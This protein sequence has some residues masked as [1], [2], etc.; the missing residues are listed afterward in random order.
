MGPLPGPPRS[1]HAAGRDLRDR[2]LERERGTPDG[3]PGPARER[4]SHRASAPFRTTRSSTNAGTSPSIAPAT[5]PR[6]ATSTTEIGRLLRGLATAGARGANAGRLR[7]RSRRRARR[8]RL[9]VRPRRIS[10]RR[11]GARSAALPGARP[12]ANRVRD[13]V[14]AL[15]DVLPTLVAALS[16]VPLEPAPP[17]PRPAGSRRRRRE[18]SRPYLATLG[19]S[20]RLRFGLVE[21]DYKLVLSKRDGV[22]DSRLTRRG[23]DEH[24]P[25]R[26]RAADHGAHAPAPE[27]A[28]ARAWR[29]DAPRCARN[30]PRRSAR[31]CAPSATSKSPKRN[32]RRGRQGARGRPL[33]RFRTSP[34]PA[35]CAGRPS[36]S[37]SRSAITTSS[38]YDDPIYIVDNPSLRQSGMSLDTVVRAFSRTL[39]D[40]LDPPDVDLARRSIT[41]SSD[42]SRRATTS[43]TSLSTRSPRCCSTSCSPA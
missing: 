2:E 43:S 37:T 12:E 38:N 33:P 13:D 36:R 11:P 20:R 23:R 34:S 40:Q 14:A 28:S 10:E 31:A 7:G 4:R 9:L 32:E 16:D 17:G 6:S 8:G 30:S 18:A 5:T 24:R 19:G 35:S 22:W 42:S 27:R 21:G 29:A 25:G 41:P 3:E 26:S 39:R 15:T 1:L